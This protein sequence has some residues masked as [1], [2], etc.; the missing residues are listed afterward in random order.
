LVVNLSWEKAKDKKIK[1]VDDR[2]LGKIKNVLNHFVEVEKGT[3]GK[4]HFF[5]PK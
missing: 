2:D 3:I 1:S 4:D 5:I